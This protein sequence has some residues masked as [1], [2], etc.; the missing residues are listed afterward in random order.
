VTPAPWLR[1]WWALGTVLL[2]VAAYVCLAPGQEIPG[3]FEFNDKL[4]HAAGHFALTCYFCGLV[5]RA[6]WY[7]VMASLMAF[8]IGVEV[9]QHFMHV[10]READKYDV[11]ANTCGMTAGLLLSHLGLSRWPRWVAWTL[12]RRSVS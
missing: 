11:L 4:W 9:A 2:V 7:Q 3:S 6:R 10:G 8:G 12:G 1:F 5:P